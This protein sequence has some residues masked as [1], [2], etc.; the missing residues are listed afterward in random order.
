MLCAPSPSLLTA[1]HVAHSEPLIATGA[2]DGSL[3]IHD[4]RHMAVKEVYVGR[5]EVGPEGLL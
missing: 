2:Y 5:H 4:V 3:T 1:L